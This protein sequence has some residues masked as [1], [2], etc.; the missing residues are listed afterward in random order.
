MFLRTI[1]RITVPLVFALLLLPVELPAADSVKVKSFQS[2]DALIE[3]YEQHDYSIDEVLNGNYIV[4]NEFPDNFDEV[5]SASQRKKLFHRVMLPLIYL[6]NSRIRQERKVLK[7]YLGLSGGNESPEPSSTGIKEPTIEGILDRY[8]VAATPSE[9]K[10][11]DELADTVLRR[12]HTIPPSLV[13]AQAATES[14]WGTSRFCLKANN[15]FGERTYDE[16]APGLVPQGVDS[17]DFKVLKFPNLLESV[18]SYVNN[19]NTHWAYRRFR[20][21]RQES[22]NLSGLKLVQGLE[23][24]SERRGNYIKSIRSLIK[25]NDYSRFDGVYP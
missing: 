7:R 6:E 23:K 22:D 17:P 10:K 24:Y 3:F 14:G 21:M 12:V 18:R 25:Y 5:A 4:V 2:V 8:E 11:N 9:V 19:L 16:D 20:V 1:R 13:L 15:L